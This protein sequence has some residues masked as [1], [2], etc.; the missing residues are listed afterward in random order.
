MMTE[1][2]IPKVSVIIPTY[3]RAKLLPRAIKSVL[4]QTFQDFELIIV[5]N[6]STD[7]TKEIVNDFVEKE[8]SKVKYFYQGNQGS[9]VARNLGITKSRAEYIA[10]L[11]SDDEWL[12]E[13]L[14]KQL[15]LFENTAFDNLGFVG[16]CN[17]D[18]DNKKEKRFCPY[19]KGDILKELLSRKIVHS[20]SGILTR[21]RVLKATGY[22]DEDLQISQDIDM[23][24]RISRNYKFDFVK[25]TAF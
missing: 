19:K 18:I 15:A 13:K 3:N 14:E 1:T 25:K 20:S 17:I 12:P 21:K 10:F 6:G 9:S 2:I 8:G 22:F 5:D 16:C 7:H 23:W 24:I 11:D 4:T